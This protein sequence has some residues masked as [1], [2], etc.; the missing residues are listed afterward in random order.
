MT[1]WKDGFDPDGAGI[2]DG[3]FGLPCPEEQAGI[4]VVGVGFDATVSYREGCAAGVESVREGSMQVDLHDPQFGPVWERGICLRESPAWLVAENER[5]RELARPIIEKGGADPG[6]AVALAEV[7]RVQERV[8]EYVRG[9]VADVL[10][11]GCV[12]GVLGGEHSVPLGAIEA[13][14]AWAGERGE[15]LGVLQIDA[16]MDLRESYEGFAQSHASVMWNV[17]ERCENVT[18][19]VQVGIRDFG[20]G[21]LE[22]AREAGQ[23]VRT[24][25]DLDL[26]R[27]RDSGKSWEAMCDQIVADLPGLVWVSF[28]IDGLEPGLCPGT[29]TPVP[30]GLRFWESAVLLEALAR[31]GK[32]AVGFDLVEVG[33]GEWDGNVGARVLYKLCGCAAAKS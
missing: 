5:A 26:W 23:R 2:G 28:D 19:L 14:D 12:A 25:F 3:V 29:G 32:R 21:E 16:H 10:G 13:A 4:V 8:R 22:T 6:D 7:D 15:A 24:W 18:K 30:G 11:A 31:S 20:R 9:S 1:D 27:A 33:G 17:L